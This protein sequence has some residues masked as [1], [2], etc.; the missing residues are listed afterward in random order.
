MGTT[1]KNNQNIKFYL[2][3]FQ[4][5]KTPDITYESLLR[6]VEQIDNNRCN[7][8]NDNMSDCCSDFDI[9]ELD[10]TEFEP[11]DNELDDYIA[12]ELNYTTNYLKKE[13]EHIAKYYDISTRRKRKEQIIEEIV[14]FEKDP[15]NYEKVSRRQQLWG[16]MQEI[17]TDKYLS[18]FLILD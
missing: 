16:Y 13:L 14:I 1:Y 11:T 2:K 8:A 15:E 3:E 7:N 9:S 12:L 18:K 17:K 4:N 6:E 5:P 10:T